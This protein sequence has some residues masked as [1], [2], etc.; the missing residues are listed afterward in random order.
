MVRLAIGLLVVGIVVAVVAP[1]DV[2]PVGAADATGTVVG[3]GF[4]PRL[5]RLAHAGPEDGTVLATYQ[6]GQEGIVLR[7]DDDGATF[8]EV[9]RIDVGPLTTLAP[10]GGLCCVEL[11]EMPQSL[12]SFPAGT[13]LW[14]GSVT[15]QLEPRR[16][17]LAIWR[18][19]DHGRTWVPH[20]S[21]AAGPGGLWEPELLVAADGSLVCQFSDDLS[22]VQP[23]PLV[24]QDLKAAVSTDG[25]RTFGEPSLLVTGPGAYGRPGMSTTAQLPDGSWVMTYELCGWLPPCQVR[26]KRS[27]DGLHWGDP[28]LQGDVVRSTTGESF[29]HTPVVS[30]SPYGGPQGT[31]VL[32]GQILVGGSDEP[33]PGSGSTILWNRGGGLG[34]WETAPAPVAIPDPF[35]HYCPNYSSPVLALDGPAILEM[36]TEWTGTACLVRYGT[37]RLP[38]PGDAAPTT[39]TSAWPSTGTSATSTSTSAVAVAPRFAG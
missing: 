33:V 31:L 14:A 30:W 26:M 32:T 25:G 37:G 16:N 28:A 13:L 24:G 22:E 36:A 9:S 21:C 1:A 19:E 23:G 39:G 8:R 4:Y 17:D 18:S 29:L 11:F 34:P 35:D 7:S 38:P 12:G 5:L 6:L 20:G 3:P 10:P 15:T 2:P 27:P